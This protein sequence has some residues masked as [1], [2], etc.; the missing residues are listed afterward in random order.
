MKNVL[1]IKLRKS[2]F[3]WHMS[4]QSLNN[5]KPWSSTT[6]FNRRHGLHFSKTGKQRFAKSIQSE[7][8]K[9]II[10][11]QCNQQLTQQLTP[12]PDARCQLSAS[13]THWSNSL[14]ILTWNINGLGDK[15]RYSD[16]H[17]I[18]ILLETMNGEN[19]CPNFTKYCCWYFARGSHHNKGIMIKRSAVRGV[20]SIWSKNLYR[21]PLR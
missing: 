8:E 3:P 21:N 7:V 20:T 14:R 11:R 1:T 5:C 10:K 18:V 15:L 4:A 2:T 16:A 13:K 9:L 17:D 12:N 19:F 6:F